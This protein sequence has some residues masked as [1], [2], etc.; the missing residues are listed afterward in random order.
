MVFLLLGLC[1]ACVWNSTYTRPVLDPSPGGPAAISP[2]RFRRYS[3]NV[4]YVKF[5][6]QCFQ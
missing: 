6:M 5:I 2:A 3:Y 4:H 1:Q